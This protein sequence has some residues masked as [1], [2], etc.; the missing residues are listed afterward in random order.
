FATLPCPSAQK[1]VIERAQNSIK[2]QATI[3]SDR[4]SPFCN[5]LFKEY[6]L[7]AISH[8][9]STLFTQKQTMAPSTCCGK[10]GE[11][12]LL[13]P[14]APVASRALFTAHAKKLELK[15]PSLAH[16]APAVSHTS[17]QCTLNYCEPHN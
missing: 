16:V 15:T 4:H 8:I 17:V 1:A 14:S 9:N 6:L 2:D 3:V 13:K 12:C 10:G 11:G 5:Q 7:T